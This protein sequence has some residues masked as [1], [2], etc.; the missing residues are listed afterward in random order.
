MIPYFM[1]KGVNSVDYLIINTLP[2]VFK[3][4]KDITKIEVPGRDG[5]LTE[6]LGSYKSITKS[7][8]CTIED[9]S[10][11]DYI[12]SWLTGS[13][14]VFFSSESTKKYKAV[15]INQIE[16]E[17]VFVNYHSFIIQFECQPKKFSLDNSLITLTTSPQTIY[18]SGSANSKPVIKVFGS[19]AIT[20]IVN[21]LSVVLTNVI[22]YV[23]I[24]SDLVDCYK[25]SLLKNNDMSGE[26]PELIPGANNISWTG[27]CS[28]V[29]IIPNWRFI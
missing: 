16:F 3:P 1:F 13:G 9:L 23:T 5:F 26:F 27:G 20:L 11:I 22:D 25:D 29:E 15:I 12:C 18:N 8:E 14:E 2:S 17:K 6:D 21:G 24:D 19:G 4:E 7:V 28:K 10:Q